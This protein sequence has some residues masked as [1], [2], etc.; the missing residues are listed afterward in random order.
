MSV[1]LT[2][3]SRTRGYPSAIKQL[4]IVALWQADFDHDE[5][6]AITGVHPAAVARVLDAVRAETGRGINA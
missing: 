1:R 3:S 5:I 2:V 4:G 6:A